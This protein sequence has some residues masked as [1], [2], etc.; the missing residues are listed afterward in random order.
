MKKLL[1]ISAF[2]V[3]TLAF[4]GTWESVATS[5]GGNK[6][7]I[8]KES[9]TRNENEVNYWVRVNLG[10]RHEQ[11]YLSTK[12]NW[13]TN[14]KTK[15]DDVKHIILFSDFDNMGTIIRQHKYPKEEWKPVSPDSI[16]D[17]IMKFVCTQ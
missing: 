4:G 12:E 8:E 7:Y 13:V 5:S 11:G 17:D 15:D 3:P 16:G 1:L 6:F 14:C 10:K 2:F 9:I